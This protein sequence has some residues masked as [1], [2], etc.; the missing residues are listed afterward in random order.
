[1][2]L[3]EQLSREI[4]RVSTIRALDGMSI[5]TK[6]HSQG[7]EEAQIKAAVLQEM[8]PMT[9][10]IQQGHKALGSDDPIAIISATDKL[11]AFKW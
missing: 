3:T 2:N 6:L 10:A 4:E 11:K 5:R 9:L 1:M 7:L 8:L